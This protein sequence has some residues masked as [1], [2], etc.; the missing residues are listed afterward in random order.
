MNALTANQ[1]HL[2]LWVADGGNEGQ[3]DTLA[4][5]PLNA[6]RARGLLARK[7]HHKTGRHQKATW[8]LTDAGREIAAQTETDDRGRCGCPGCLGHTKGD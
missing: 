1:T 2:I 4:A 3:I 7:A 5:R 8:F 6:L